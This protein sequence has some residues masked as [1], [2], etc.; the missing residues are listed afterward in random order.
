MQ[1]NITI[2]NDCNSVND[3]EKNSLID[4]NDEI[5]SKA[6]AEKPICARHIVRWGIFFL[7]IVSITAFFIGLLPISPV[8][9]ATGSMEPAINIGD[10]VI[11]NKTSA[12]E[13]NTGDIIQYRS[14]DS[15]IIHRI[16]A[17]KAASDGDWQFITKGDNNNGAD[18]VPVSSDQILGKVVLVIPNAGKAA[19]WLN[20]TI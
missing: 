4:N 17:K 19:L 1:K 9:I 8:A 10:V 3:L 11:V 14:G 16:A 18:A 5:K 7:I 13:L 6:E 2:E 20:N 15:T 12:D